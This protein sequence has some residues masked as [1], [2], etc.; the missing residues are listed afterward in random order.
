[1]NP[2]VRAYVVRKS[3]I[4]IEYVLVLFINCQQSNNIYI[5]EYGIN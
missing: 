4:S 5:Y 2:Y 3:L 1:M